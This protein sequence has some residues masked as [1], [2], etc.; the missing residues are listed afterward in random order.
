MVPSDTEFALIARFIEKEAGIY[1]S[2]IKKPLLVSRIGQRLRALDV[3]SYAAYYRR[4]TGGDEQE[5]VQLINAICTHETRFFREP[6]HFELLEKTLLPRWR[7]DAAEGR[8]ERRISVWSAGC[9]SGEE[10]YSLAMCLAD[11][12]PAEES[13]LID[14]T[15][16]DLSTRVLAKAEAA[17]FASRRL[18][19]IPPAVVQRHMLRGV[20]PRSGEIK[21]AEDTRRHVRFKP[22][23]LIEPSYKM[24]NRLDLILCRNVLIYFKPETRARVVE[25]LASHLRPGGYLFLG[26]AESLRPG[27]PYLR[28]EIPTVYR[29]IQEAA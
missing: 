25:Q 20:G 24:P 3:R 5:R 28:A 18:A 19:E 15:A 12:L 8:R 10:P 13:W 26:H 23:N 6:H 21:V 16:T 17:V 2:P 14:I 1:L 27:L 22:L 9:S 4:I 11:A 7:A 29:R